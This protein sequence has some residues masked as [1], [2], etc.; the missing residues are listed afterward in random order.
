MVAKQNQPRVGPQKPT[1][2]AKLKLLSAP[3][4]RRVWF[5]IVRTVQSRSVVPIKFV[6]EE[7]AGCRFDPSPG[8]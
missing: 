7:R 3:V 1:N 2:G 6:R 4:D 8:Y 5:Y